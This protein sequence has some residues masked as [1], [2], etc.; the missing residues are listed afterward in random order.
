MNLRTPNGQVHWARDGKAY[1]TTCGLGD[2]GPDNLSEERRTCP[3]CLDQERGEQLWTLGDAYPD[4]SITEVKPNK[5][6]IYGTAGEALWVTHYTCV[7]RGWGV[8]ANG[9]RGQGR[10]VKGALHDLYAEMAESITACARTMQHLKQ[11]EPRF[12]HAEDFD[13][14]VILRMGDEV[15]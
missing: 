8:T 9:C 7:I 11:H 12:T 13:V 5:W 3:A 2:L 6:Y 14:S 4:A 1:V 15:P 10:T